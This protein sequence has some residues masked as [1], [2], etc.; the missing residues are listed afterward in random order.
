MK[1]DEVSGLCRLSA[2]ILAGAR[3]LCLLNRN[4][5]GEGSSF[6]L[7]LGSVLNGEGGGPGKAMAEDKDGEACECGGPGNANSEEDVGKDGRRGDMVHE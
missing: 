5:K 4:M 3:R 1:D 2:P 6:A 7:G